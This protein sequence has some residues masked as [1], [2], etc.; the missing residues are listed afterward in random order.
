MKARNLAGKNTFEGWPEGTVF[1]PKPME[2]PKA[3][4]DALFAIFGMKPVTEDKKP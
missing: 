1:T 4:A 3:L 2:L